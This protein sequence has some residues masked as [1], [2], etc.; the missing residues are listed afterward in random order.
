MPPVAYFEEHEYV[1]DAQSVLTQE[2][3]DLLLDQIRRQYLQLLHPTTIDLSALPSNH[4]RLSSFQHRLYAEIFDPD[5]H[6]WLPPARYTARVVKRFIT[7]IE[8]AAFAE[9]YGCPVCTACDCDC[10][11]PSSLNTPSRSF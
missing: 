3:E 11:S 1:E 4:L 8:E 5:L 9:G 7:K 2:Q 6:Q 10:N